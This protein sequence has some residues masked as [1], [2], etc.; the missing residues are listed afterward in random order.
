M[1]EYP[2]ERAASVDYAERVGYSGSVEALGVANAFYEGMVL[3]GSAPDLKL[4]LAFA[5]G[6]RWNREEQ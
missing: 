1:Y 6:L 4:I 2:F 5:E 3:K